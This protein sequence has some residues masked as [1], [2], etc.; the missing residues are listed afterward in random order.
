MAAL[1]WRLGE[2]VAGFTSPT[3]RHPG[4]PSK[5]FQL[6]VLKLNARPGFHNFPTETSDR[7]QTDKLDDKGFNERIK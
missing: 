2:M 4:E 5:L 7:R 6:S 3:W 1:K